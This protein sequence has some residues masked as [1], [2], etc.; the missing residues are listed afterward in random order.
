GAMLAHRPVRGVSLDGGRA[1]AAR[2]MVGLSLAPMLLAPVAPSVPAAVLGVW[3]IAVVT[4]GISGL[5]A[6][7]GASSPPEVTLVSGRN[8]IEIESGARAEIA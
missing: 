3:V 5:T 2:A 8:R 4:V 6:A 7:A 1:R